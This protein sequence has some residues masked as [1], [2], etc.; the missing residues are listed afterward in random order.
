VDGVEAFGLLTAHTDA[1]RRDDP[2]AR[3]FQHLGNR[4]GQVAA[5]GVGLDDRKGARH[6]HDRAISCLGL[7]G[8]CRSA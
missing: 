7:V 8:S 3:L 5:G 2:Q 4:A 1:L 6:G